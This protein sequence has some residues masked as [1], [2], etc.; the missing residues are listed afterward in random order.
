MT[1]IHDAQ[2]GGLKLAN[3]AANGDQVRVHQ[4]NER[5]AKQEVEADERHESRRIVEHPAGGLFHFSALHNESCLQNLSQA[6]KTAQCFDHFLKR[7]T[8]GQ[9]IGIN[10][11]EHRLHD[12]GNIGRFDLF[13]INLRGRAEC[14]VLHQQKVDLVSVHA[15]LLQ[16]AQVTVDQGA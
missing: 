4:L 5:P 7:G 14:E 6:A 3:A 15:A 13:V 2:T 10:V 8:P 12:L 11:S 1:A 9:W 16:F